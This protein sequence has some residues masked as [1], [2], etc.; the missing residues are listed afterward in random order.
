MSDLKERSSGPSGFI[1]YE[2]NPWFLFEGAFFG[3]IDKCFLNR[4]LDIFVNNNTDLCSNAVFMC[5]F[6]VHASGGMIRAESYMCTEPA[7]LA[8]FGGEHIQ[9]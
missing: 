1:A 3:S 5:L 9:C 6:H 8:N 7:C 2:Y 4:I